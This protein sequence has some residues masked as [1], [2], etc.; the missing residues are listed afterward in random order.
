MHDVICNAGGKDSTVILHLLHAALSHLFV[1]GR[2]RHRVPSS[3]IVKDSS[4]PHVSDD[5]VVTF[6]CTCISNTDI[7]SSTMVSAIDDGMPDSQ[8]T[9][10]TI[11]CS[12]HQSLT[13]SQAMSYIKT[14]YFDTPDEFPAMLDFMQE[15]QQF[16]K[17]N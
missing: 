3:S 15:M 7:D 2:L 13:V 1:N 8:Y 5:Q 14:I 17:I 10:K 4:H 9:D 16:K 6:A 12:G 11:G